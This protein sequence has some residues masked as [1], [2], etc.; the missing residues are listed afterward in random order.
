MNDEWPTVADTIAELEAEGGLL[1]VVPHGDQKGL[2]E[3]VLEVVRAH[4]PVPLVRTQGQAWRWSGRVWEP[5]TKDDIRNEVLR[6]DQYCKWSSYVK[7]NGHM[8]QVQ[9]DVRLTATLMDAVTKLAWQLI[10]QEDIF[11]HARPGLTFRNGFLLV[12]QDAALVSHSPHHHHRHQYNWDWDDTAECPRWH[13][14]LHEV[15]EGDAEKI[16]YLQQFVGAALTGQ[17]TTWSRITLL[18]GAGA[19]GK[20]VLCDVLARLFAQDAVVSVAPQEMHK[21]DRLARLA[22]AQLNLVSD[23]PTRDLVDAGQLKQ[24]VSGDQVEARLL[25]QNAFSFRAKAAHI[26]SANALPMSNDH[27]DGFFRRWVVLRFNR[28]FKD[29]GVPK[30]QLVESLCAEIPG[31]MVWAVQGAMS[32]TKNRGYFIPRAHDTEMVE[33]RMAQD[34]VAAFIHENCVVLQE[35]MGAGTRELYH[36][37]CTWVTGQGMGKLSEKRFGQRIRGLGYERKKQNGYYCWNLQLNT[38]PNLVP[39]AD[40]T[41]E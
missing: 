24:V 9:S 34:Q 3:A 33:W 21:S 38:V 28:S 36:K 30:A 23:I 10:P 13:R 2:A 6:C 12:E 20:S 14:F 8:Q 16:K 32:V 27:S 31:I 11:D 15:F 19:N 5:V 39:R 1:T 25:Y 40:E 7:V 22:G 35:S 18:I 41:T 4:S 37:Y 29:S 17:A 26:F